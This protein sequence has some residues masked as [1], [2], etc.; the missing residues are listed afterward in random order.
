MS[1]FVRPIGPVVAFLVLVTGIT[2]CMPPRDVGDFKQVVS[3]AS[4]AEASF[5][6]QIV[7]RETLPVF[8]DWPDS[9]PRANMGWIPHQSTAPD[10]LIETGDRLNLSVWDNDETSLLSQPSQKVIQLPD[11]RVSTTGTIFL[12]YIDEVYVAKMTA[13]EARKTIQDKMKTIIPSAQVQLNVVSGSQ[14]SVEIISGLPI[15]GNMPLPDRNTTITTILGQAG[16]VPAG[17][18]NPQINLQRD[19]KLYRI[20]SDKLFAHPELDT[21]MRGGDKIFVQPEDRFFMSLGAAGREAVIPFTD[22]SMTTLE[23][24]S[25]IGGVNQ[26]TANPKAVLILRNYPDSAVRSMLKN[27]PPKARMVFAFDLTHADGLFSA[28]EFQI[29]DRDLVLVTTSPLLTRAN[30]IRI[31]TSLFLSSSAVFNSFN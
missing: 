28:G 31:V 29:Q 10:A 14:N 13:A 20:S 12:P 30:A 18:S 22:D 2:A 24:M 11:L 27:G 15:P 17:M 25:M 5:S 19:G 6:L 4:D 21:V 3:G 16:G 26:D 7:T 8:Q 1:A 23:V 9:H